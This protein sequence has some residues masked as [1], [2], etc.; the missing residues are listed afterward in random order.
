MQTKCT[1][2]INIGQQ[3]LKLFENFVAVRCWKTG[4]VHNNCQRLTTVDDSVLERF[5]R[6]ATCRWIYMQREHRPTYL[7]SVLSG[8]INSRGFYCQ[9]RRRRHVKKTSPPEIDPPLLAIKSSSLSA[10]LSVCMSVCPSAFPFVRKSQ[11]PHGKTLQAF[12]TRRSR[13]SLG[14]TANENDI[15]YVF[16]VSWMTSF[17]TPY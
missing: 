9:R 10:C 12:Y 5:G 3:L 1:K 2:I 6:R 8:T 17:F 7:L 14:S 16:L 11:N 15:R 4:D 13:S